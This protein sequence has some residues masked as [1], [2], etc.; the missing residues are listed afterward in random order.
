MN[1]R[2]LLLSTKS[3]RSFSAGFI[4]IVMPL[5][6]SRDFGL[7]SFFVGLLLTLIVLSGATAT[8]F[9]YKMSRLVKR[10]TAMVIFSLVSAVSAAGMFLTDSALLF[11]I[12]AVFS[13]LSVNGTD[14]GP[15]LALENSA[16]S[17]AS[18][19]K[20]TKYFSAYNM[21]GNASIAIGAISVFFFRYQPLRFFFLVFLVISLVS[22]LFYFLLREGRAVKLHVEEKRSSEKIHKLAMLFS[23]D[24]FGGG[25]TLQAIV[26]Y[27]FFIRFG[28]S[29]SQL[30]L[31]FFAANVL[32]T[33]S[34]Y[35]SYALS[36]RI[37]L[38]RTM[39]FTHIP[40]NVFLLLIAIAPTSA[41]AIVLYLLRESLAEMDIPPRQAYT[42]MVIPKAE[43]NRASAVTHSAR[44]YSQSFSPVLSGVLMQ[45]VSAGVPF[46]FG[47]SLKIAYDLLIFKGFKDVKT[48]SK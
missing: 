12:F 41:I 14:I 32:V 18:Y 16:L 37:G 39:V 48:V 22:A 4:S 27:F 33:V 6:F 45:T 43:R 36:K 13:F 7:S 44:M 47:G 25:F 20:N 24:S 34:Y 35:F 28:V 10:K 21:L 1:N 17:D 31:V 5:V 8:Y 3:L 2:I 15:T 9:S 42:M 26:A 23:I 30:G 11:A 40:S 38:I 19:G 29:A 46:I